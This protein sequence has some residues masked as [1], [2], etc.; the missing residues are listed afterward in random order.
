MAAATH[1]CRGC[2]RYDTRQPSQLCW[3]CLGWGRSS[4]KHAAPHG[5][6]QHE[7]MEDRYDEESGPDDVFPDCPE[8]IMFPNRKGKAP[9]W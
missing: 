4:P 8:M 5:M 9:T 2:G 7:A 6:G 1:V 3:T